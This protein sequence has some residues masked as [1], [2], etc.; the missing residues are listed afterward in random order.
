MI[1]KVLIGI[2]WLYLS[3]V[4]A[5]QN[6]PYNN[7]GDSNTIFSVE[8]FSVTPLPPQIGRDVTLTANINSADVVTG[9]TV[10]V[11]VRGMG[12]LA[13]I[14]E[15]KSLDLCRNSPN[16]CPIPKGKT[17][18]RVTRKIPNFVPKGTYEIKI[19]AKDNRGRE[20]ICGSVNMTFQRSALS[21]LLRY[22]RF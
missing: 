21:R 14:S 16:G 5:Q 1:V 11:E 19:T 3:V 10:T 17:S 18:L 22:L 8:D 13:F 20:L 12:P 2:L 15:K 7:C 4:A 6:V 9:G